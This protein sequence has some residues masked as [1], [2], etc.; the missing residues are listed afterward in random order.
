MEGRMDN[1]THTAIGLFLSRAGLNRLTPRATPILLLA[2]NA[3][4]MDVVSA[5]G[6]SLGYIHYHR[7]LTH[8]LAALPLL[9]IFIVAVVRFAG[10]KPVNWVGAAIAAAIGI[11]SHLLLDWTNIYGIRML[12]PFSGDWLRLDITS[13]IDLWIWAVCLLCIAGPF[14]SRLV[15]SEIASGG[16]AA[17]HHGRGFAIFALLFVLSYNSAR[18][19]LHTRAVSALSSRL[20]DGALPESVFAS[21]DALNPFRWRG[22]VGT[23]GAFVVQDLNLIAPD[24]L[25]ARPAMFHI[26]D[27]DPAIDAARRSP[28]VREF[29]GFAQIP[30]W[31]VSPWPEIENGRLVEV[32]DMRFGSPANPGFMARA[33][34]NARDEVVTSEFNFGTP[35]AR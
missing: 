22:V 15:G 28:P 13:V 27:P 21:P 1:L 34:I 35:R 16:A 30:L 32:F 2:A 31:R 11:V 19:A 6:G 8:S 5:A 9:A 24:P 10:R 20:Y 7:H 25:A 29:L 17:R 12:L 23:S 26:P 33:V 3:P 14:L 18:G 4:D